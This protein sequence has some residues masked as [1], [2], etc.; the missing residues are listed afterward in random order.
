M[1]ALKPEMLLQ[2]TYTINGNRKV[3]VLQELNSL[4]CQL[5]KIKLGYDTS[6]NEKQLASCLENAIK[7]LTSTRV[8]AMLCGDK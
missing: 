2:R 8:V 6:C 7:L 5:C 1:K 3:N 4:H